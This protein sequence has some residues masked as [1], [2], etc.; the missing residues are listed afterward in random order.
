MRKL[1]KS[2]LL[3]VVPELAYRVVTD[4]EKY[5]EF[6]PGCEAVVI[7]K[8]TNRGLVAEMTIAGM[9]MRETLVTKN[10]HSPGAVYMQLVEGPLASLEGSWSFTPI[11]DIGCRVEV[12]LTF[13][14]QGVLGKLL[15]PIADRVADTLV[16]A[17]TQRIQ[18]V[19]DG[20]P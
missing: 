15:T 10:T 16:D 12:E 3:E 18:H 11:G 5:P 20:C 13:E 7:T 17:F 14:A 9:G 8:H 6:L 19:A 2:A 1:T 4:V